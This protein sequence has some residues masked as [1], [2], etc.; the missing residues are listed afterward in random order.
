VPLRDQVWVAG[1]ALVA[2]PLLSLRVM[3]P[4]L[5]PPTV[6]MKSTS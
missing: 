3:L 5:L 2:F 6:G 4:L 1:A